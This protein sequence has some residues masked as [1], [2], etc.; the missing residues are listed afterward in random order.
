M[1]VLLNSNRFSLHTVSLKL[2][3]TGVFCFSDA[4]IYDRVVI[5]ELIK[6]V[7]QSHQ[8]ESSSQ[9]EFKGIE[10]SFQFI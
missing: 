5:Q 8:L 2:F 1:H 9:K 6:T 4:G 3:V 10:I 7:A